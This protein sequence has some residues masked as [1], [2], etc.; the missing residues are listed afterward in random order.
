[1]PLINDD[2]LLH[3]KAARQL[4]HEFA[5]PEPILDYHCHLDPEDIASNRQF[6]NLFEIWLEGDHYKWRAMRACGVDENLCTGTADP[7]DKF[8]AWARTVPRLL[9]N[10]LY[11]WTHLELK[12][13][14]DI[15]LLLNEE[16]APEIWKTTEKLLAKNQMRPWGIFERFKVRAVCT[17]DDPADALDLHRR[18][19]AADLTT[20]VFPTFRPDRA[21]QIQAGELWNAWVDRLQQQC[22]IEIRSLQDFKTALADR[23]QAFHELG[24]RI[25]DHGLER[26]FADFCDVSEAETIFKSARGGERLSCE[27][28][29]M[30]ASHLMLFFGELDATKGWT[31]QLHLGALRN[32]N[33]RLFSTLGPD[34][35]CDSI[36]DLPQAQALAHYLSTLDEKDMLPQVILYNLN[37]ADNYVFASMAANFQRGPNSGKIQF[38]SGWWHLDQKEGMEWQINALSS[39]GVLSQFIGMLT[40][41]R[42]FLSYTRHEYFRR[43]LCNLIG[44][45]MERGEIPIDFD[46]SGKLVQDICYRNARNY[47]GLEL[48]N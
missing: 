44:K 10:P 23:H 43:C 39:L 26:C 45:D 29:D 32:T 1:M 47:F 42:S 36:G 30:F 6:T 15:D 37:P 2:F 12:R 7:Y 9:R 22:D 24:C 28:Q 40:D 3:N 21:L 19:A 33:R 8:I 14:F 25:S 35:G 20:R 27:A 34:I 18:I 31:K 5:A 11:H 46:L 16:T 48:A 38:G 41:S 4:Y 13:Y 17:T